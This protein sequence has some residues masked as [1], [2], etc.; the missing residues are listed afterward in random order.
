MKRG[1]TI[2]RCCRDLAG[3]I[4]DAEGGDNPPKKTRVVDTWNVCV[5]SGGAVMLSGWSPLVR[6][7]TEDGCLYK[8]TLNNGAYMCKA[9]P[10]CDRTRKAGHACE[11][12]TI[13]TAKGRTLTESG[14]RAYGS[15]D[16]CRTGEGK[17][18]KCMYE[19]RERRS[20]RLRKIRKED[21]W[22]DESRTN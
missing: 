20:Q 17:S 10:E 1:P 19:E 12:P 11:W 14:T 22:M 4:C 2:S 21:G 16:L 3:G 6:R 8:A 9:Y 5:A 18:R 13:E 7:Q 15:H